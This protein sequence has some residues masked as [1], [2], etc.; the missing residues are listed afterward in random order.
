MIDRIVCFV[1]QHNWRFV[2]REQTAKGY[3]DHEVCLRC[4]KRRYK[5]YRY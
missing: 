2:T 4:N 5:E 1:Y 3:C